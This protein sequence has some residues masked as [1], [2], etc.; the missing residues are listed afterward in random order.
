MKHLLVLVVL[1]AV[2]FALVRG[3]VSHAPY[4]YDEADYMFAASL[5]IANNWLDIGSMPLTN[6]I[7][8]GRNRG[9]DSRQQAGLSALARS[10]NDPV[11]YRHWHGPLYY[12]WLAIPS[13]L[14]VDEFT[15]RSL[16][17]IF[18]VLT[19]LAIYFGSLA[20]FGGKDGAGTEAH[21]AAILASALFLWSPVTLRTSEV[22]PHLLFVLCY[23]C[24]L[25]L[26]AKAA[27]SGGRRFYYA[28]VVFCGL[29]FCTLEVTFVLILV[30]AIFAWQYR[31]RLAADWKF[32]RNSVA[33]LIATVLVV[34][35]SG[36]LKLSFA[37]A[38]MVM[39]YLAVFRKGAWG[40]VTFAQTWAR[41][42]AISPIEWCLFA[43]AL[44]S[45]FLMGKRGR[46]AGTATFLLFGALMILATL[47]VYAEGPHYMT[48][49]FAA[50]E[51]F[52]GWA[53]AS[54]LMRLARPAL[55]YGATGLICC[56]LAWNS[57][58]QMSR[59]PQQEDP[60]QFAT[61]NALRAGGL[62]EKTLLAPRLVLPTLHYYF[63]G[64]QITGYTGTEEIARNRGERHFDA[65]LYPDGR[66][67][68]NAQ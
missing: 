55:I 40:D 10:G 19:G 1:F 39:A 7:S 29:A 32:I 20:V 65:V 43:V 21:V 31:E 14:R 35:P 54:A 57:F 64:M 59:F 25:M 49:F 52:T 22:A 27:E 18:P 53:L 37:K 41:R 66:V 9:A 24:G 6:F 15:T 17:L 58:D 30:L 47:R 36:L 60:S 13:Y 67:E 34:W 5:G 28:A 8:A 4:G 63:P 23:V 51:V 45:F 16:F 68:L 61:I 56:L 50:L 42:F 33:L 62:G 3:R 44:A 2:A 11:V 48:P 46:R 26:L 38:Y 12:F